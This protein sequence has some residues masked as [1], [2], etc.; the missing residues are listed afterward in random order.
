MI[1]P[2]IYFSIH[3]NDP[4]VPGYSTWNWHPFTPSILLSY[5]SPMTYFSY[6]LFII[7]LSISNRIQAPWGQ[8]FLS[9]VF[10]VIPATRKDPCMAYALNK[11]LLGGRMDRWK[12]EWTNELV[13]K[14]PNTSLEQNLIPWASLRLQPCWKIKHSLIFLVL[15]SSSLLM[16][17][18]NT[19]WLLHTSSVSNSHQESS[20]ISTPK[21][22][23]HS[24]DFSGL[25]G[26]TST[27]KREWL[28]LRQKNQNQS[29]N[30]KA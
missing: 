1:Y 21:L 16:I 17:L 19:V 8:G 5:L 18:P 14:I 22:S 29:Q 15:T 28:K 25:E 3:F 6:F 12:E 24:L 4:I 13:S 27:N 30:Q 23:K 11:Y 9:D 26:R 7:C 10:I 20:Q 2:G